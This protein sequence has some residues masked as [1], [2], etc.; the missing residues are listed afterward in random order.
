MAERNPTYFDGDLRRA[1]LDAAKEEIERLGLNNVS[2]RSLARKVGVSHAAPAHHFGNR[3]GLLSALSVE[4]FEALRESME[5]ELA[6]LAADA[7]RVD[8]LKAAGRGYVEFTEREPALFAVMF[9]F[10][11]LDWSHPALVETAEASFRVL[12]DAVESITVAHPNPAGDQRTLVIAAWSL[13]HGLAVLW[14][15]GPLPMLFP[16]TSLTGLGQRATN[17]FAD[18]L[19]RQTV[20]PPTGDHDGVPTRPD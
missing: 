17:A 15:N 11:E 6:G 9:L 16:E 18:A 10:E 8:R 5:Q 7:E 12:I 20:P 19:A 2:L 3:A 4:A 14:H 13:V 1:L